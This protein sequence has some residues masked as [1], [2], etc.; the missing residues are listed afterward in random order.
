MHIQDLPE[1]LHQSLS[2]LFL[3]GVM[4]KLGLYSRVKGLGRIQ[5]HP[6]DSSQAGGEGA[7]TVQKPAPNQA[8]LPYAMLGHF[9]SGLGF[10]LVV[11]HG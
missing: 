5:A 8:V 3:P 1:L 6:C 11:R 2:R 4:Q 7:P 10:F 9:C